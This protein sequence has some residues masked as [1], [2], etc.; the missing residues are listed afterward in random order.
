M[1]YY[2]FVKMLVNGCVVE[3]VSKGEYVRGIAVSYRV[4]E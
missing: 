1:T 3:R 2:K 4:T